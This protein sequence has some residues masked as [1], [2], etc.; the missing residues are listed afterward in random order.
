MKYTGAICGYRTASESGGVDEERGLVG[1]GGFRRRRNAC[2][3]ARVAGFPP[4]AKLLS[5]LIAC[6]IVRF[7]TRR[8]APPGSRTYQKI[9]QHGGVLRHVSTR[10]PHRADRSIGSFE[11]TRAFGLRLSAEPALL[12]PLASPSALSFEGRRHRVGFTNAAPPAGPHG[13]II[14][15]L[16]ARN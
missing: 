5:T 16:L 15:P 13:V 14:K 3:L 8:H 11:D 1:I 9:A 12:Y 7:V 4:K 2:P 6:L 10:N